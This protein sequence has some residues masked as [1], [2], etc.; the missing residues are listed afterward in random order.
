VLAAHL[1][2]LHQQ[3]EP[4]V[5]GSYQ[6]VVLGA[7]HARRVIVYG[8]ATLR[9]PR[10]IWQGNLHS[11]VKSLWDTEQWRVWAKCGLR[12]GTSARIHQCKDNAGALTQHAH[13][14]CNLVFGV[15]TDSGS[16][17]D[18]C[19]PIGG[20]YSHLSAFERWIGH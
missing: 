7:D 20:I 4:D 5:L 1:S 14:L 15:T 12:L 18:D 8:E 11:M 16:L 13:I 10:A 2:V 9:R 6:V 19:D 17:A 3:P